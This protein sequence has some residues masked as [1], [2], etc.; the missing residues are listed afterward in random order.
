MKIFEQ[1]VVALVTFS[2]TRY[3]E[4][5]RQVLQRKRVSTCFF[6]LDSKKGTAN[7][8][9][10]NE[11]FSFFRD[12][13]YSLDTTSTVYQQ[14]KV[15]PYNQV[16]GCYYCFHTGK[17]QIILS[18]LNVNEIHTCKKRVIPVIYHRNFF[19]IFCKILG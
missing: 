12:S 13:D 14:E 6:L 7:I 8:K 17:V 4:A 1:P 5:S 15:L 3:T 11:L 18:P 19:W 16:P 2:V 9:I 10:L